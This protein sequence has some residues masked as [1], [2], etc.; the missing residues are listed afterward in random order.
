MFDAIRINVAR[1]LVANRAKRD[2]RASNRHKERKERLTRLYSTWDTRSLKD[3]YRQL[4]RRERR[5]A[6]NG[7]G[8]AIA[9]FVGFILAFAMAIVVGRCLSDDMNVVMPVACVTSLAIFNWALRYLS[10]ALPDRIDM[11]LDCIMA[12]L[13][14]DGRISMR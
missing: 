4:A 7:V 12:N 5:L 3:R 2:I 8:Y 6:T 9:C 10:K 11:E 13:W 14:D 1:M